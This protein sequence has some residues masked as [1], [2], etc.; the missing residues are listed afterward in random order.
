M[1]YIKV[2][3]DIMS[4]E[5]EF[6]RGLEFLVKA[7]EESNWVFD[8]IEQ[9]RDQVLFNND[10][11]KRTVDMKVKCNLVSEEQLQ[12]DRINER[13]GENICVPKV[14]DISTQEP[15]YEEVIYPLGEM[16]K[17]VESRIEHEH[18]E[19]TLGV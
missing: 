3:I 6:G 7:G 17:K 11:T 9:F 16:A 1:S 8:R 4:K 2:K 14:V 12:V 13:F 10:W 15:L 18:R 19:E 5:Y